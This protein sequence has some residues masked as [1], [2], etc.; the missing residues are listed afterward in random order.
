MQ[1]AESAKFGS[2]DAKKSCSEEFEKGAYLGIR[3]G[4]K[5]Q[6]CIYV[7]RCGNKNLLVGWM[8]MF[9]ISKHFFPWR[10][11]TYCI[12]MCAK[13]KNV[14]DTTQV[15]KEGMCTKGHKYSITEN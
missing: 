4:R 3:K 7:P 12:C 11:I 2:A 15:H 8:Y 6:I 1:W 14:C 10:C 5:I 9:D 13:Y